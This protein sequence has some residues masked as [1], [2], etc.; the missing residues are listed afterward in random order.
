MTKTKRH[1]LKQEAKNILQSIKKWLLETKQKREKDW[2][3][4]DELDYIWEPIIHYTRGG[5][6][7]C[8]IV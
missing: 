4:P 2:F 7:S 6:A 8:R 5:G 3:V 1:K